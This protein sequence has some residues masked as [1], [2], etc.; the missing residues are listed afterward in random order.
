LPSL[1]LDHLHISLLLGV[2][3]IVIC[4]SAGLV[5]DLDNA[6]LHLALRSVF[7]SLHL[8]DQHV[9]HFLGL[10]DRHFLVGQGSHADLVLL[11]LSSINLRPEVL[12]LPIV[13]SLHVCE[14]LILLVL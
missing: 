13:I 6:R 11:D 14:L 12:E 4:G 8:C 1:G 3:N 9:L 10:H 5:D 2:S 7:L